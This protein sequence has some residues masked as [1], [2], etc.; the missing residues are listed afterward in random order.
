MQL[1]DS[2]DIL[3]VLLR[4]YHDHEYA[5]GASGCVV[6]GGFSHLAIEVSDEECLDRA[7]LVLRSM[8]AQILELEILSK[9]GPT[10]L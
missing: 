2:L 3:A 9:L 8:N 5:V 1:R 4:F 7:F 10:P 6:H